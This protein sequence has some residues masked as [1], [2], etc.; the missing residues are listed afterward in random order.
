MW[1]ELKNMCKG[2]FF[3]KSSINYNSSC[4]LPPRQ[5]GG[6]YTYMVIYAI[7]CYIYA[8]KISYLISYYLEHCQDHYQYIVIHSQN[9]LINKSVK[10]LKKIF[11]VILD[12]FLPICYKTTTSQYVLSAAQVKNFLIFQKS[13][14]LFSRYSSFCIFNHP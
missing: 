8:P 11:S 6:D 5:L 10:S 14:V 9:H 1:S 12:H 3:Q 2:G 13:Y 7:L 4:K